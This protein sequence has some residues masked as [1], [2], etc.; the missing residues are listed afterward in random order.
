MQSLRPALRLVQP[1]QPTPEMAAG[2]QLPPGPMNAEQGGAP[3]VSSATPNT[4]P[5]DPAQMGPQ[6]SNVNLPNMP[7]VDPGL[8]PDPSM[9]PLAQG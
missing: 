6:V 7:Q 5:M 1:L 3:G 2:G 4:A 9:D 8:L